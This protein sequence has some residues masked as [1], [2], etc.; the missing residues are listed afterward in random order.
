MTHSDTELLWH[1]TVLSNFARGYEKYSRVYSKSRIAES[2]FP[3]RFFLLKEDELRVGIN[4]AGRLLV[5]LNLPGNRLIGLQTRVL[6]NTLK[7][8]LRTGLGRYVES[9]EIRVEGVAFF[10]N[11][12]GFNSV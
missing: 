3:D 4:K 10:E 5:K 12:R 8:N 1:V 2:A 6:T 9:P 11:E 7:P